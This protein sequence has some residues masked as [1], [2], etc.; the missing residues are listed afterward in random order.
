M[1]QKPKSG[2]CFL[3]FFCTFIFQSNNC[4]QDSVILSVVTGLTSVYAATV[5]YSIIG[6]R[7]AEKYDTCINE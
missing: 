5:T 3:V 4:V 6:F 1:F 7:A 2:C